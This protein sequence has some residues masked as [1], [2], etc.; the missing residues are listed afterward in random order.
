MK[1]RMKKLVGM[2]AMMAVFATAVP[3]IA[4]AKTVTTTSEGVADFGFPGDLEM[5]IHGNEGQELKG[6]EFNLYCLLY[7]DN[8]E[9]GESVNY[10][11]NKTFE[12]AMQTVVGKKLSKTPGKVTEY[13]IIDYILILFF[14]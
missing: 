2:L 3:H 1:K 11:I 14:E 4:E 10:R 12:D 7:V 13:E 8:A 6:K 9:G 5:T